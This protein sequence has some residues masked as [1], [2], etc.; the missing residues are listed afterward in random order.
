MRRGG[1]ALLAL[2]V[3]SPDHSR[4][5]ASCAE[6]QNLTATA[7][8]GHRGTSSSKASSSRVGSL[9]R[10]VHIPKTGG[11]SVATW[12]LK[13][14]FKWGFHAS[15]KNHPWRSGPGAPRCSPWHRPPKYDALVH[16]DTPMF[17]IL[18]DPLTRAISQS[19]HELTLDKNWTVDRNGT[20]PCESA[21][22]N[23]RIRERLRRMRR[24]PFLQD[25]HWL[26]QHEY[27]TTMTGE[28][29][30]HLR[31]FRAESLEDDFFRAFDDTTKRSHR[32]PAVPHKFGGGMQN[33]H[34]HEP[35]RPGMEFKVEGAT[36]KAVRE[37][38]ARDYALLASQPQRNYSAS[39]TA[40]CANG[41]CRTIEAL[42]W[43][44][45]LKPG[46]TLP[47]VF[48]N[49]GYWPTLL[50]NLLAQSR[51]SPALPQKIGI[52]CLDDDLAG[53]LRRAGAP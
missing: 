1:L 3:V 48:G 31:T 14:G 30:T 9:G 47:L 35:C 21:A 7:A 50:N 12:G 42:A 32:R 8:A 41:V 28:P 27:T 51:I 34:P 13:L 10:F 16:V 44:K 2:N 22:I 49:K 37:A 20:T 11:T 46:D 33:R 23:R 18:R 40:G 4:R 15:W 29:F 19:Q 43:S 39:T 45:G 24:D 53:I 5:F 26:P 52:V 6:A 36:A 25:C 38:Y 17:I